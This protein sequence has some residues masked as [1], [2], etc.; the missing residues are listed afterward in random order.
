MPIGHEAVRLWVANGRIP[1][2]R[3]PSGRIFI[4]RET[5]EQIL[6]GEPVVTEAGV[7]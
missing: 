7:A 4:S 6:A 3:T 5:V 1:H 2:R